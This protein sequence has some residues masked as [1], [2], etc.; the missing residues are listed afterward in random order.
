MINA[1]FNLYLTHRK[2]AKK[3]ADLSACRYSTNQYIIAW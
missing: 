1:R 2:Y 3:K